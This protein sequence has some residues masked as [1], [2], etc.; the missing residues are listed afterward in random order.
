MS[1]TMA[2]SAPTY[3]PSK[4]CGEA[5]ARFISSEFGLPTIIARLNVPYGPNGG[6]PAMH[7]NLMKA[8][9]EIP[10]RA[11]R[12]NNYNPVYEDDI[13]DQ[14]QAF[15]EVATSPATVV[16]WCGSE[17]VSAEEWCE[18]IGGLLGIQPKFRY[19]EAFIAGNSCDTTLM[20]QLIGRT[21]VPWRD[22]M[23]RMVE[24]APEDQRLT[25]D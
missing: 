8:G 5:V 22:G 4:L 21:K 14:V 24:A 23:R 2:A 7:M 12:P 13:V 17:T 3:G 18:Y 6:L 25:A 1:E 10:L 11:G 16:N 19:T 15:C 9:K 20:H